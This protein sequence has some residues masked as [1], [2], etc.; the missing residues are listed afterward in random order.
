MLDVCLMVHG[1]MLTPHGQGGLVWAHGRGA[2]PNPKCFLWKV[3]WG[4]SASGLGEDWVQV[5]W[6]KIG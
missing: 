4:L 2:G 5:V 6:M 3:F 1:P